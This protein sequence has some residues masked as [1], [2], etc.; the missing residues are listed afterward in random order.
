MRQGG[1]PQGVQVVRQGEPTPYHCDF[2]SLYF[3]LISIHSECLTRPRRAMTTNLARTELARI[4]DVL[5]RI[6]TVRLAVYEKSSLHT[7]GEGSVR[8]FE[9]GGC[10]DF[11][12]TLLC[13][14]KRAFDSK[15]WQF[16]DTAL[17]F[18]RLRNGAYEPL[19]CF[20]PTESG[21]RPQSEYLCAPDC[22]RAELSC[23]GRTV[24]L[25]VHIHGK[26][27]VQTVCYVYA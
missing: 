22:Y 15:R 2:N 13:G 3:I 20:K 16:G 6:R 23:D 17:T 24:R 14:G 10:I 4:H 19:F 12:E 7:E 11:A 27:K 5:R 1:E 9:Q 26:N 21:W 18:C 8:V 25:T